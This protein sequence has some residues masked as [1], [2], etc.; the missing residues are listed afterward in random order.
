MIQNLEDFVL[1]LSETFPLFLYSVWKLSAHL[2]WVTFV[3]CQIYLHV[4]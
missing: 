1:K 2:A 3:L 4:P